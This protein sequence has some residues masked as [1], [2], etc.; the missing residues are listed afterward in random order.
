MIYD[1]KMFTKIYPIDVENIGWSSYKNRPSQVIRLD[2]FIHENLSNV[3]CDIN[4]Y[5]VFELKGII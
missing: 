5:L 3:L 4:K 2:I 1:N